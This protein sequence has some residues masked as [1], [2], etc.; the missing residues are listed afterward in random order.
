MLQHT[1]VTVEQVAVP[2]EI[3]SQEHQS[4]L[5]MEHDQVNYQVAEARLEAPS[6]IVLIMVVL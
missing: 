3:C 5:E 6:W 2:H 4:P 1:R